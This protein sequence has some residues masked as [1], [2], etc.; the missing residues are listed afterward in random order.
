MAIRLVVV[1]YD[2]TITRRD[3]KA[4][5]RCL[6]ALR[7]LRQRGARTA[8]VS[9]RFYPFLSRFRRRFPGV[10][11]GFVAENGCIGYAR[12]RKEVLGE[13]GG[14]RA[15]LLHAVGKMGI[16]WAAGEVVV[17]VLSRDEPRVAPHIPPGWVGIRNI[18]ALMILPRG[19]T[20]ETGVRWLQ[21]AYG[22]TRRETAGAGDGEN[23]IVFRRVCGTLGVPSNAV[24][25]LRRAADFVSRRPCGG[26][27]LEF[28]RLLE[29][30]KV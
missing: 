13:A 26:G 2:R 27:T 14:P 22:V 20:K 8:I 5:L 16:P 29:T 24:P 6:A 28:L 17:S 1:D 23:D 21:Q 11:D 15:P 3:L 7:R 9:G 10:L 25:P 18:D 4:D 19:V 30:M 12:G